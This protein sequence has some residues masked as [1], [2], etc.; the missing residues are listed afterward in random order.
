M[1]RDIPLKEI[2]FFYVQNIQF[3]KK[4]EINYEFSLNENTTNTALIIGVALGAVVLIVVAIIF[5]VKHNWPTHPHNIFPPH[6]CG[7]FY[8]Q[9]V[10]VI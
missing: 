8:R 9:S 7:A 10:P 1:P 4:N 6:V 2:H 3:G 5:V